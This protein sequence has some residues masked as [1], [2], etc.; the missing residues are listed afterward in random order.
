MSGFWKE[1]E[2]IELCFKAI[3][4]YGKTHSAVSETES[5]PWYK[6][7]WHKE[8]KHPILMTEEIS[9]YMDRLG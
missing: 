3:Q 7:N 1:V 9:E 2:C 5:Y 6:Y 4:S 8:N